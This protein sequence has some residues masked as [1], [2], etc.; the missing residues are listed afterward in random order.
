MKA[1]YFLLIMFVIS[2]SL[3]SLIHGCGQVSEPSKSISGVI[4]KSIS[5]SPASLEIEPSQSQS[6]VA[7][8]TF[9]DGSS[10]IINPIWSVEGAIGTI[11]S[12]GVFTAS[13]LG[14]G[15]IRATSGEV[16]TTANVVVTTEATIPR[17]STPSGLIVSQSV[18]GLALSWEANSE[19]NIV[20]YNIYRSASN[21]VKITSSFRNSMI[22][23]RKNL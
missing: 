12:L 18:Y 2:I 9:S 23:V 1:K 11:T 4:L 6:F 19:T 14:N 13:S 5:L 3:I 20:G 8:G 15:L 22:I 17:P 10:N 7:T 16:T 21:Y